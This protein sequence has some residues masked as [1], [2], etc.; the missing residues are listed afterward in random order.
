MEP[1]VVSENEVAMVGPGYN[2]DHYISVPIKMFYD[3]ENVGSIG[4]CHME[5]GDETCVF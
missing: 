1:K 3:I 4:V 2:D 5:P